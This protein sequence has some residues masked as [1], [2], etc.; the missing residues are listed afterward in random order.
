MTDVC[1]Y[2]IELYRELSEENGAP[3][4]GT[5]NQVVNFILD[6]PLLC[7]YVRNG[8]RVAASTKRQPHRLSGF[9]MTRDTGASATSCC[10]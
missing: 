2:V 3:T 7:R 5:Q 8:A 1:A 9:P 10:R 6:D 4:A